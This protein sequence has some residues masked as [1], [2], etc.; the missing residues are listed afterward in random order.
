MASGTV[1]EARSGGVQRRQGDPGLADVLV[2]NGRDVTKTDADGRWWLPLAHGESV[3]V[4]KPSNWDTPHSPHGLPRFSY[5]HQPLGSPV[6]HRHLGVAPTGPLPAS[7]DF[8]LTRQPEH[9]CFEAVLLSD[10]QPENEAEL[11][12]LRDDII[13]GLIGSEV[14]FGINH[15]DVVADDLTLYPRYL[16]LLRPTG[17]RWHHCPGNHDLNWDAADDHHARETWKRFFGPRHYAFQYGQATFILL[18]NVHYAGRQ[19]NASSSGS[20]SGRFGDAQL[21]FVR[22]LL[23]HV[24]REHL[25][26]V[27][28]HI[29]LVSHHDGSNPADTTVDR[30]ALLEL[31]SNRLHT[32]SLSGHMHTTEHHYLGAEAV[33]R[34]PRRI[35]IMC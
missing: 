29:P 3:F 33:F 30:R 24:P 19:A 11:A 1:F 2:S 6:A 16:E 34:V 9:A 10:T 27:S 13:V 7:I 26:V 35:I 20:Y 15:G 31:L 28:M 32:L 18:D 21:Q 17:V 5:L 25:V 4:I 23:K 22:N 8:A 14:A 12:Y